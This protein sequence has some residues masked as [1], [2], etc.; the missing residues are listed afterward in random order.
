[1][2][3]LGTCF[4]SGGKEPLKPFV[5]EAPDHTGHCNLPGY[6]A[7]DDDFQSMRES[8]VGFTVEIYLALEITP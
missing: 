5:L 6:A 4:A 2:P 8:I 3:G 7:Q 1:M